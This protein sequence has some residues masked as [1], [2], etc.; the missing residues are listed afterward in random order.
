MCIKKCFCLPIGSWR[1]SM[2]VV[3]IARCWVTHYT[4]CDGKSIRACSAVA[5]VVA[6][7]FWAVKYN[8][9]PSFT[10]SQNITPLCSSQQLA[11]VSRRTYLKLVVKCCPRDSIAWK[12]QLQPLRNRDCVKVRMFQVQTR[13]SLRYITPDLTSSSV[14]GLLSLHA[15]IDFSL[16]FGQSSVNAKL[17]RTLNFGFS[18]AW[19]ANVS[20]K[21][22]SRIELRLVYL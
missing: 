4:F 8:G 16:I 14:R 5:V 22:C 19:I 3:E 6:R 7:Q 20:G 2:N 15:V 13:K 9:G 11:C 21:K 1:V 18:A 10:S 17:T 12:K